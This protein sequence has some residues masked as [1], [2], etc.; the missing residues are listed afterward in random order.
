M[1]EAMAAVNELRE[2]L[3]DEVR[4]TPAAAE[5]QEQAAADQMA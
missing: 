1:K 2:H 3:E 5:G 4:N